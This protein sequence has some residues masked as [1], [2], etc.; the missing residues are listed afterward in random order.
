MHI[1]CGRLQHDIRSSLNMEAKRDKLQYQRHNLQLVTDTYIE[2]LEWA[3]PLIRIS[4]LPT[5]LERVCIMHWAG[6]YQ[7]PHPE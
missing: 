2:I 6:Y 5:K 4:L 7:V 3:K 1:Y